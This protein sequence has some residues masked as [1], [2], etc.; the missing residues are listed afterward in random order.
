MSEK[1]T[2]ISGGRIVTMNP[3]EDIYEKGWILLEDDKIAGI[4]TGN[5]PETG[6]DVERINGTGKVVLPGIVNIHT[7]VCGSLFKALTEDNKGS[8]YGLA[9][10]M[11]R[12]LTPE[13][14]Y[15]VS[16]LGCLET[17]KFGS[18]CINDIYHFMRSTAK[19][20]DEIGLRGVLAQKVYE[21]DLCNLQYNDYTRIPGQGEA[22]LEENVR[23]IEEYHGKANGR[24]TCRFGPHA[25]DTVSMELAKKISGLA[26]HYRVGI[27]T[28]VAQKDKEV[29]HLR[30]AY[31]LT[32][33]EY[34][35]ETG[36]AG[37]K[38]IAAHCVFVD[39]N[40]MKIMKETETNIAHCPEIIMKRGVFPP[41]KAFYER[42]LRI[43]LGTDWVT[44][45]PWDNMRF[46]IVG[47]RANGCDEDGINAKKVFRMATIGAAEAIGMADSIGSLEVGKKAD[48]LIMDLNLAHL[49]PIFDNVLATIVYNA[50]G[51]EIDTVIIDGRAVVRAGNV[52][53]V[54]EQA[55]IREAS[56]IAHDF[57][58]R[59]RYQT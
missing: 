13:T 17:V 34:L 12:F 15:V 35:K 29:N 59:Q 36:L 49:Q 25:T 9:F 33:V 40:D 44:M 42:G 4:G 27:H 41:I 58:N 20:V 19:A 24:I 38:L 47:A 55:L 51:N 31:N 7:H 14:T 46:A 37:R 6:G 28:H 48:V 1:K 10:P 22:K 39:E 54:D 16:M 2:L 23:L 21:V 56:Q 57:L 50:N 8:F 30:E 11:E 32:P 43:A 18:T 26:E 5:P 45:N 53:T 52:V 3:Q